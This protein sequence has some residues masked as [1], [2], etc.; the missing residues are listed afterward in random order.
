MNWIPQCK[1][2]KLA[3][4]PRPQGYHDIQGWFQQG[5]TTVVSM[6]TMMEEA[7]LGLSDEYEACRSL[8][9]HYVSVPIPDRGV[10]DS[11][12]SFANL[13]DDLC[14]RIKASE[15]VVIHCRMGIGRSGLL[16][17]CI[18]VNQGYSIS[19]SLEAVK[20]ARG[21]AIPD[22]VEQLDWINQYSKWFH[23]Q[24]D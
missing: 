18:L 4:M 17:T 10:P 7:C 20:K 3:I 9:L 1:T 24:S 2:G 14:T 22:T 6:L 13:V 5:A 16:C 23:S 15:Q 12:K 11:M 8:G 21:I 19:D